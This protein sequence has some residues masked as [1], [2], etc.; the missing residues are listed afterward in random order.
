MHI[1]SR[2]LAALLQAGGKYEK[3]M[4]ADCGGD[5]ART[6]GAVRLLMR[7]I[8]RGVVQLS[9]RA[10]TGKESAGKKFMKRTEPILGNRQTDNCPSDAVCVKCK[11]M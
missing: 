8:S 6:G 2:H 11:A 9:S 4:C 10:R 3:V 7:L 5:D 1:Y